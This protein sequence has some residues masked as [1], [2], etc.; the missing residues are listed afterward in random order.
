MKKFLLSLLLLF[1]LCGFAQKGM[2]G[3]GVNF[4]GGTCY[5]GDCSSVEFSFKYQNYLHDHIRISPHLK[6]HYLES[7]YSEGYFYHSYDGFHFGCDFHFFFTQVRRFRAYAIMGI[8]LGSTED[9]DSDDGETYTYFDACI[10]LGIGIDYRIGY[11]FSLQGEFS[12]FYVYFGQ[13]GPSCFF[14]IGLTYT[15]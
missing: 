8:S 5:D 2:Q 12:P 7:Y 14:R 15:F 6:Y 10:D 1:P 11:H 9:Y 4:G 3:I 13:P